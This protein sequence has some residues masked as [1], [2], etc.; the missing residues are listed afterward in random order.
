MN[1]RELKA[2]RLQRA[3]GYEFADRSLLELALT[4]RSAGNRNNERLEFLGDSIV[5]HIIAEQLYHKFPDA[6]EGD[7]SRMRAA[8]VKGDTLAEVAQELELGEHLTLGAGERKS[9]GRRRTSILADALE[10][11][12]GA[13]LLD[14]DVETCRRCVLAWFS[15]RLEELDLGSAGKDAKT[16]LQE[17]LQGRGKPLPE[18]E[19]LGVLGD[20]HNQ[21]F[22]V[23][24]RLTKPA[25]VVEGA[26]SSRRK[27]E[28][29]AARTAL[30]R[31]N[32]Y[33]K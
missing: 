12:T 29:A 4:H 5:N 1:D 17:Y 20:D 15:T 21:Q 32:A 24:C 28:Q 14:S 10:A 25:L 6:R 11:V 9:G 7:M 19:L 16:S 33:G 27:A 18:Y 3:L 30:E 8:L 13:I 26:G 23:A 2:A 22:H 31:L